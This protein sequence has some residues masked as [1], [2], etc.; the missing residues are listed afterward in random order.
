[1]RIICPPAP[2]VAEE[3]RTAPPGRPASGH[4]AHPRFPTATGDQQPYHR[5]AEAHVQ[6]QEGQVAGQARI[7]QA[8]DADGEQPSATA[9]AA[10]PRLLPVRIHSFSLP[11]CCP[12]SDTN[13]SHPALRI[14]Q[15][16]GFPHSH[17]RNTCRC[18][19]F[20]GDGRVLGT[21]R[22]GQRTPVCPT[23]TRRR[24][25]RG[26]RACRCRETVQGTEEPPGSASNASAA[27]R[28]DGSFR[29]KKGSKGSTGKSTTAR[30]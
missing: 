24:H 26:A 12:P 17:G 18:R 14:Q 10:N 15:R 3:G 4:E 6:G 8:D 27:A 23:P 25:L 22:E 5:A 2:K 30:R 21:S 13:Q 7:Q 29:L 16:A 20:T 28:S 9:V 19:W 11:S 1:M